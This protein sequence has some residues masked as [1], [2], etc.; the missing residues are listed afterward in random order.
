MDIPPSRVSFIVPGYLKQ[1]LG[2]P[3]DFITGAS[4][5]ICRP[6]VPLGEIPGTLIVSSD[7]LKQVYWFWRNKQIRS[8]GVEIEINT[9]EKNKSSTV[10]LHRNRWYEN[11]SFRPTA[12]SAAIPVGTQAT[13]RRE[14]SARLSARARCYLVGAKT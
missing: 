8:D 10:T 12:G 9:G 14:S 13:L 7:G 6:R 1:G 5:D 4:L 3:W 11:Y 2:K